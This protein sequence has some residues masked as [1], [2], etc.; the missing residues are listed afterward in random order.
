[1]FDRVTD[2]AKRVVAGNVVAGELH[3]LACQRHLN[4]LDR[5]GSE[6]FPFYWDLEAAQRI[7]EYA[8]TLTLIEGSEPR[9]LRLLDS[10]AFD[11]GCRFGW[12]KNNGYR[13][14]R[15]SYKSMARQNGENLLPGRAAMQGCN[16]GKS[17][18]VSFKDNS[19]K[20]RATRAAPSLLS[21]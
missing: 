3:R 2:Y 20:A 5:E 19:A 13:R 12:K 8:E 21:F 6:D 16:R 9:P 18:E 11:L 7:I 1:M 15:R 10:Q 17:V 4:D 14:F